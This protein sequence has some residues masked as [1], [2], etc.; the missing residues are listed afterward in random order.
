MNGTIVGDPTTYSG[1]LRDVDGG[2]VVQR[3]AR[4]DDDFQ[5]DRETHEGLYWVSTISLGGRSV[6]DLHAHA[7]QS[8]AIL[9]ELTV[10]GMKE[11]GDARR[12]EEIR[13]HSEFV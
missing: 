1:L 12:R 3:I 4:L 13:G 9:D 10:A 6:A 8:L 2:A 7:N 11:W 5:S